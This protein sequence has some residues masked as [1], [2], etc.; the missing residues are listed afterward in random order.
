MRRREFIYRTWWS[1]GVATLGARANFND[2]ADRLPGS[3][4]TV[5]SK[6]LDRRFCATCTRARLGR[7]PQRADRISLGRGKRPAFRRVCSRIY[8]AQSRCHCY[9]RNSD[10]PRRQAGDIRRSHRVRSGGRPSGDWPGCKP[11]PA[12]RQPHRPLAA[13]VQAGRQAYRAF[14]RSPAWDQAVGDFLVNVESPNTATQLH[15][16]LAAARAFGVE[17]DVLEI[18]AANDIAPAFDKARGRVE[19]LFVLQ[20]NRL[21]SRTALASMHS[22]SQPDCRQCT[23]SVNSSTPAGSMSYGPHF[24]RLVSTGR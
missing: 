10:D 23:P 3:A 4:D 7:R 12:R 19:A 13:S 9:K 5:R 22:R 1:R 17:V 24:P 15:E 16:A 18:R 11:E 21:S 8:Q 6:T 20:L 2:A 14:A